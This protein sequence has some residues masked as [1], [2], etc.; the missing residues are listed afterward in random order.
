[1][2]KTET[3]EIGVAYFQGNLMKFYKNIKTGQVGADVDALAKTLGFADAH[4]L[5]SQD[6]TLDLLNA[7]QKEVGVWPIQAI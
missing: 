5:L 1:M 2:Q 4:D 6:K 3:H 7:A